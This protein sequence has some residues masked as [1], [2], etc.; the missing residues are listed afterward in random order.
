MFGK[1]LLI[2]CLVFFILNIGMFPVN[3]SNYNGN[4]FSLSFFDVVVPDDYESIQDAIDNASENDC[5]YVKSGVYF[6]SI[7]VDKKGISLIG[8][9]RSTIIC[10]MA[11]INSVIIFSDYVKI[12]NFSI[13]GSISSGIVINSSFVEIDNVL[14]GSCGGNGIELLGSDNV[15]IENCDITNINDSAIF[16]R[17]SKNNIIRK[18]SIIGNKN[19]NHNDSANI[20]NGIILSKS[21]NNIIEKNN[22][23]YP[24]EYGIDIV[25][26][27]Q[28]IISD[29]RIENSYF[30]GM[31]LY[32]C[33]NSLVINNFIGRNYEDGLWIYYSNNNKFVN[34]TID[35]NYWNG[36]DIVESFNNLLKGNIISNHSDFACGFYYMDEN[37]ITGNLFIDNQYGLYFYESNDN[38]I[39]KNNFIENDIHSYFYDSIGNHWSQNYWDDWIGLRFRFGIKKLILR[40]FPKFISGKMII[41]Q[42]ER[43]RFNFD[44]SPVDIP[45]NINDKIKG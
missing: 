14:V 20:L 31:I 32:S 13:V 19:Y 17:E 12:S 7:I 33:N 44:L 16:L 9:N 26:S 37:N 29:N 25:Y 42:R 35:N 4:Y 15:I 1:S 5:I 41:R 27:N 43:T 2:F 40:L 10:G 24:K 11:S 30:N 18:N 23:Q 45:Y 28:N 22:I 21:D 38:N 3:S 36:I 34:N 39:S 8:E 6:E